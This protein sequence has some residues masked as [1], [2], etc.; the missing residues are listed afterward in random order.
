M[1]KIILYY[2]QSKGGEAVKKFSLLVVFL[3]VFLTMGTGSLMAQALTIGTVT[4]KGD[5]KVTG[6]GGM[7]YTGGGE[8]AP[9]FPG[10]AVEV[11]TGQAS[12]ALAG[13]GTISIAQNSSLAFKGDVP[14]L[15]GGT[16]QVNILPGKTVA[17][18]TPQ[19]LV[20]AKAGAEPANLSVVAQGD[21]TRVSLLSGRVTLNAQGPAV[22]YK[23]EGG[24][25]V[26]QGSEYSFAGKGEAL[27]AS[28]GAM[29][30]GAVGVGAGAT[31]AKAGGTMLPLALGL[32]GV[33][34]AAMLAGANNTHNHPGPA[35]P[36]AP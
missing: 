8:E 9:L 16:F 24:K 23:V 15:E 3:A 26:F 1:F 4:I 35:S 21:K 33:S 17:F 10:S 6:P 14:Y 28:R 5:V 22:V 7:V 27:M 13:K 31:L 34:A 2:K 36:Y 11:G 19:G 20:E 12:V 32:S 18:H 25:Y 29:A 30:G